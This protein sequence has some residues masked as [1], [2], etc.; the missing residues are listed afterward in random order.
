M[1]TV[2]ID[3]NSPPAAIADAIPTYLNQVNP[4][5]DRQCPMHDK[6]FSRMN[7]LGARMVRYLHWS[8][9]QAPFPELEEGVFDFNLTDEYIAD[10]MACRNAEDSVFNFDAPPKWLH[11]NSDYDQP[12]RD[13]TGREVGEWISRI[14]GWYTKGGFLDSRTGRRYSSPHRFRW[15]NYEVLNEPNLEKWLTREGYTRLY[16]GIVAILQRDHPEIQ[17]HALSLSQV[18]PTSQLVYDDS[19]FTYFF[20]G[21]NHLPGVRPPDYVT[22]HFYAFLNSDREED[23]SRN[24][25]AQAA[26]FIDRAQHVNS[27]IRTSDFGGA[28]VKISVNE[29]GLQGA[30]SCPE[31]TIF[32][33]SKAF[34]N[35]AASLWAYYYGELSRLGTTNIAASQITGYP[36]GYWKIRGEPVWRNFPCVSMMDWRGHGADTARSWALQMTIDVLGNYPKKVFV[37]NVST[38]V[39]RFHGDVPLL[40]PVYSIGFEL[41][42]GKR[43]VL[44]SNTN[45][46]L[47]KVT[48]HGAASGRINVVDE[49]A[50]Y[51]DV[52]YA[53][54]SLETDEL[55]LR[56]SAFA[57]IQLPGREGIVI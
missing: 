4:S 6:V 54:Y 47:V 32:T 8:S 44:L 34:W 33:A 18:S 36:A 46:S 23:W 57:L 5:M 26:N 56:G 21:S 14:L 16:D 40:G 41:S 31:A 50:G 49:S 29:V 3:W 25:F 45:S 24:L 15:R 7:H 35:I 13:M 22:Y 9:S 20:N 53:G 2:T 42:T 48:V 17:L 51:A 39:R 52:P 10:F 30:G 55:F 27:L 1:T 12:L 37:A 38:A 43:V 28:D 19:W 11:V